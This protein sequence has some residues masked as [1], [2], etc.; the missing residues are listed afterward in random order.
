MR[1]PR[2]TSGPAFA[3]RLSDV[4]PP[5]QALVRLCQSIDYGQILD[6]NIRDREPVFHPAPRVLRDIKLDFEV[7]VRPEVAL[8]DFLLREEVCRLLYRLDEMVAGRIQ[9]IEVRAGIPQRVVIE[10]NLTEWP[11]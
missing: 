3:L 7:E 2:P 9:R 10:A 11:R 6:L 5:R 1:Q 8:D 4:S